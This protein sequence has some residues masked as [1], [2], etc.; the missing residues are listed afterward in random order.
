MTRRKDG[1]WEWDGLAAA[2][3]FGRKGPH[4]VT[5][6]TWLPDG[7]CLTGSASGEV[8]AWRD[9]RIAATKQ[10]HNTGQPVPRQD[11]ANGFHG[12]RCML[13]KPD[14]RTLVTSGADGYLK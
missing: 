8:N 1:L 9:A 5:S 14:R 2:G 3:N 6:A 4:V 12:V 11:G 7:T 13:L 10:A